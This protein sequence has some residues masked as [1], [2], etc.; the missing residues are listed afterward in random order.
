[1]LRLRLA[2]FELIASKAKGVLA[3]GQVLNHTFINL[4]KI[5]MIA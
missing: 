2:T 4:I 1:M 5:C 3:C